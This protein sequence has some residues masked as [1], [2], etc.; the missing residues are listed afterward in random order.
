MA[1]RTCEP[2]PESSQLEMWTSAE[3]LGSSELEMDHRT[4]EKLLA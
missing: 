4:S 1:C 2:A 3:V